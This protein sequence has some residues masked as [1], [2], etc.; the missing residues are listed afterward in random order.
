MP[1]ITERSLAVVECQRLSARLSS[2]SGIRI[3][4]GRRTIVR[5]ALRWRSTGYST[6]SLLSRSRKVG[7]FAGTPLCITLTTMMPVCEATG[8]EGGAILPQDALLL[9]LLPS[10]GHLV[11]KQ[12]GD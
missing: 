2:V 3:T 9:L 12:H 5:G 8:M 11:R 1:G 7:I 10:E 6:R 4:E